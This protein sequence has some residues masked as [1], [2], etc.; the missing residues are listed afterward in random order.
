MDTDLYR[1][2]DAS[3]IMKSWALKMTM[4]REVRRPDEQAK[5]ERVAITM[6]ECAYGPAPHEAH[7]HLLN[8][9]ECNADRLK[10]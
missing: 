9:K 1:T 10:V 2:V 4:A 5:V 8:I 7:R 3:R 6:Q